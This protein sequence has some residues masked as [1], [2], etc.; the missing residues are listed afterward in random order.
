VGDESSDPS[1][2]PTGI[3]SPDGIALTDSIDDLVDD[4]VLGDDFEVVPYY[5][6]TV[7]KVHGAPN[8]KVKVVVTMGR[9]YVKVGGYRLPSGTWVFPEMEVQEA[10]ITLDGQGEG[11]IL[12][13]SKGVLPFNSIDAP[14]FEVE[15]S[16]TGIA[17]L[18]FQGTNTNAN[19]VK[20]RGRV[21]PKALYASVYAFV[22]G[23]LSGEEENAAGIAGDIVASFLSGAI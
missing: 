9:E 16:D 6:H 21:A 2:F 3:G 1:R 8:G 5:T 4:D 19:K 14:W 10:E 15:I 7:L 22:K 17:M 13:V 12:L 18:A 20:V 23:F 11:E